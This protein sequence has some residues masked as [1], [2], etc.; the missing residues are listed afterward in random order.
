MKRI[1]LFLV[2]VLCIVFF[3][4]A[5]ENPATDFEY[6]GNDDN[7]GILIT[8]YIG[9]VKNVRIPRMIEGMPVV[10][11]GDMAFINNQLTSITIPNSVVSIGSGAFRD[12][13]LTSITIPNSVVSIGDEAFIGN[14]LTSV[15]LPNN[16]TYIGNYAFI[17]NLL[18]SINLPNSLTYIG[19]YAFSTN[20]LTRITITD[21]VDIQPHS[22]DYISVYD[23]YIRE[24][25]R[26]ATYNIT[27][28]TYND[29]D[30]AVLDNSVV[31]IIKYTGN[32][33]DVNIP[34]RINN[35]PVIA[36]GDGAFSGY[37]LTSVNFP[38]GLTHI[39]NGAFRGSR[40]TSVNLPNSLTHIGNYAFSTNPLTRIT[41]TDNVDIQPHSFYYISVYDKYIREGK[42]QATYNITLSTYNDFDIAILDNSVVEIIRYRRRTESVNIP[43]RINNLPV[44]AIGFMAF[45]DNQL[46]SLNLPNGLKYIGNEAFR[47][48]RLTSVN[49]PNSLTYIGNGAFISN[50]LTSV[51]LFNGLKYIGD[52]AFAYNQ[53]TSVIIPNSVVNLANN[54]FDSNVRI[55]RR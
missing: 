24:G 25:K 32:I 12:N 13:Q 7:T 36:I 50:L 45:Y 29:F 20:R 6:R 3:A 22:F 9:R 10:S 52:Y 44:I 16:L 42:R 48:S 43:E 5:Q 17:G 53:L 39:G 47:G 30:I 19:N 49:L 21:N 28:S 26:Q 38:N 54:A 1:S 18:T 8:K 27:L 15:N 35:L 46:T 40:L 33:E 41:I 4:Y 37:L 11:I 34:E 14:D 51:N 55:T 2:L 23:K 31:E